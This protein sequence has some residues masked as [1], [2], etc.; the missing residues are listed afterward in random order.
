VF[1]CGN[2]AEY[3]IED[4]VLRRV[5]DIL[6]NVAGADFLTSFPPCVT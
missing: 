2:C 6:A 4:V 5:D 3:L 1:Q